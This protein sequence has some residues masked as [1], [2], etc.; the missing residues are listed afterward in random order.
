LRSGLAANELDQQ[1]AGQPLGVV[2]FLVYGW[3][4]ELGLKAKAK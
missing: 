2:G 1:V 3:P 4:V